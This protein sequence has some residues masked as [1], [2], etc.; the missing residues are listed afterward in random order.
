MSAIE[1]EKAELTL[2]AGLQVEKMPAHWLM[3]RL[4][5]R[6]LRPGGREATSWMLGQAAIGPLDDVVEFAPGLG[7]TARQILSAAPRTYVG[8]ER[9]EA[10][11]QH[12]SR[13]IA[14]ARHG[15]AR[16]VQGDASKVPLEDGVASV[17][18]GEAMLSMQPESR[19]AAIVHEAA[20]LLRA[21]GRYAIHELAVNEDTDPDRLAQIQAELS[22]TIHVGVRI[23]RAS[24]WRA[25]LEGAGLQ[26]EAETIVPM[27]LLELDRLVA[28]E[29]ILGV[30]RFTLNTLRTPG[31]L[32]RLSEVRASFRRHAD[33]LCAISLVARRPASP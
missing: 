12:A 14:S 31:A 24:D 30:T 32:K 29:G 17:V 15:R 13:S 18:V 10:A 4:G 22:K 1:V 11:V 6:V 21:G 28:D 5:K 25:L 26:V 16:V 23:G 3:A 9:D 2:G 7:I 27:R 19:K 20:R 8:V 33:K